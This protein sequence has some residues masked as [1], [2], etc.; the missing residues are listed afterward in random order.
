MATGG[1]QT[2][3]FRVSAHGLIEGIERWL[4]AER[5]QLPL[6][7]PVGL[8][9][10]VAAWYALPDEAA[11]RGWLCACAALA[12][13]GLGFGGGGRL[14]RAIALF[15]LCGAL[16]CAL[17]WWRA[18]RAA[19][20]RLER[21][22]VIGVVARI[23]RAEPLPARA[24]V[25]LLL[26]PAGAPG[27]PARVRVTVDQD[28]APAGLARGAIV[29]LRA[30][31]VPPP[32][33]AVPGAY[34][35]SAI[36]WFDGV[37]AS[38]KA[39]DPV[40][41]VSAAP[42][43]GPAEW[44]ASARTGLSAHI[45]ARLPGGAGGVATALATGDM[46]AVTTDDNDAFR[47][48]GLAHLLSVSGLHLTAAVGATM[49]LVLRLLALS[50]WLALRAP[51]P[52]VAAGAG[53]LA[54]IAYTL[55][56][57]AEVPTVRS[58]IAALIV[59]A[60]LALGRETVTLR[61]VATGATIVVLLWPQ[62]A[63][64][65]SFQLSFAAILS[66][67]ALHELPWADATFAA[68]DE[69]PARRAA[70][71]LGELLVTGLVVEIALMPIALFHFH[72]AGFYG[73]VAN[74]A[75]IP[76]T[77]FVIMPAE[78]IAL[79][80]DTIGLGA[81]AWWVAGLALGVL[82]WLA[83]HVAVLPGAV[84]LLP[85]LGWHGYASIVAGG[86]WLALW[87]TRVRLA[88]LAPILAGVALMAAARPA[89]LLVTGDGRHVALRT[90]GG[91]VALLRDRTGDYVRSALAELAGREGDAA[92]AIEDLPEA[93]C[94]PDTCAAT[95]VRGGRIW[96]LLATRSRYPVDRGPFAAACAT[97][98]IVVSDRRLPGWCRPRWLK[99]DATLLARTGGLAIWLDTPR[100]RSVAARQAG[101]PWAIVA[102]RRAADGRWSRRAASGRRPPARP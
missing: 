96:R 7:I 64:G 3:R 9:A 77:T 88:G 50:P 90:R 53:A 23:E 36:A 49:V 100:I 67:V 16:G 40:T 33:A 32:A 71:A 2:P 66:I 76:L 95:L 98:D 20:P 8:I 65:A 55:L 74:I 93:R 46:G 99:A 86:L 84:A 51:L 12:A 63:A 79:L 34:D 17:V 37:G 39:L 4:E 73:A 42:R 27:L 97:A 47:R 13:L 35:Y 82:L 57:G 28:K 59:L 31:L 81:P 15:A 62:S 30:R 5:A 52:L 94:G 58:L 48:S 56:T 26:A 102:P 75:A 83:H 91:E 69:A 101:H 70:R 92:L 61:L 85:T 38:G 80:L 25:R 45:Q 29:R 11:W 22:Q 89:D 87:R 60:G 21:A 19:A 41:I 6:W 54:G 43:G 44:L 1:R 14:G 10:G 18:E 78:A 24:A 68:R 72:R